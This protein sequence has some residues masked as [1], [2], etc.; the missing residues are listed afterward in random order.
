MS[1]ADLMGAVIM[2][3]ATA[4]KSCLYLAGK[5]ST[6]GVERLASQQNLR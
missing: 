5:A 2:H 3:P 4:P 1:D 6:A